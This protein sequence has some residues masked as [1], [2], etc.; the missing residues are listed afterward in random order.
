MNAE[1]EEKLVNWTTSQPITFSTKRRLIPFDLMMWW[2]MKMT[3]MK[4]TILRTP[5]LRGFTTHLKL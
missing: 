2:K 3:M 4:M 1:T 5:F